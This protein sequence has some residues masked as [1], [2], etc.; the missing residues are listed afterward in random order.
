MRPGGILLAWMLAA[1]WLFSS[2]A[3]AQ[4]ATEF[5]S[6][7]SRGA[8]PAGITSGPDGNLCFTEQGL[9]RIA[10]REQRLGAADAAQRVVSYISKL[11]RSSW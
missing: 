8:L 10:R 6:G 4:V 1:L 7:I 9:D 3:W 11:P 2:G 5:S